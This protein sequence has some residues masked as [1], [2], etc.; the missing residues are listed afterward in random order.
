MTHVLVVDDEPDLLRAMVLNLSARGYQVT[1]AATGHG[2][3]E[4]ASSEAPDLVILDLGLPDVDG[5]NVIPQLLQRRPTL[6]IVV[7]SARVGSHDK[8]VALDLGATDYV[9]KPFDINELLARLR[10]ASRRAGANPPPA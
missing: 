5:L 7:L 8:V 2:A 3:V 10:A 4:A 6:P 9:T 1:T